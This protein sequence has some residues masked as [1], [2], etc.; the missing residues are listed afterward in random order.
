[1]AISML[2]IRTYQILNPRYC[3]RC[4]RP[5]PSQAWFWGGG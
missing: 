5:N 4:E 1:M 3:G 2:I